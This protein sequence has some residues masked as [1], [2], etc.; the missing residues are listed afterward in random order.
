MRHN[1]SEHGPA[2]LWGWLHLPADVVRRVHRQFS[3]AERRRQLPQGD[4][5]T[6]VPCDTDAPAAVGPVSTSRT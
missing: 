1:A 2:W 6:L 4:P 5:Q 3:R